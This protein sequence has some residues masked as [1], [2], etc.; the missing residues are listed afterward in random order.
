VVLSLLTEGDVPIS[1]GVAVPGYNFGMRIDL[2]P[3]L[4]AVVERGHTGPPP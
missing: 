3:E 2:L 4:R 1:V